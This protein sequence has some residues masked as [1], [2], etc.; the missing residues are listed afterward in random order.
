M[1]IYL[2]LGNCLIKA[3]HFCRL[4]EYVWEGRHAFVPDVLLLDFEIGVGTSL[5]KKYRQPCHSRRAAPQL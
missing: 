2:P 1:T 3:C 4:V 5:R